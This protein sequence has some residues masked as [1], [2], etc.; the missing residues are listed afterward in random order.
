MGTGLALLALALITSG[1]RGPSSQAPPAQAEVL[2]EESSDAAAKLVAAPAGGSI[3]KEDPPAQQRRR[4]KQPAPINAAP[5]AEARPIG[6]TSLRSGDSRAAPARTG[7]FTVVITSPQSGPLALLAAKV[8]SLAE[9]AGLAARLAPLDQAGRPDAILALNAAPAS[10][11]WYCQPGSPGSAS[12]AAELRASLQ[13]AVA[14]ALADGSA[15]QTGL[16]CDEVHAGRARVAATLVELPDSA[17]HGSS[18]DGTAAA[19]AEGLRRYFST[20]RS[21]LQQA[22]GA[23]RLIWPA[24]GAITSY[25]GPAHP[26]GIDIGQARGSIV[27]ATAGTVVWAGR[28][29]AYGLFVV[30]D[31]G[32]GIRTLYAHLQSLAVS[33]GQRVQAGQA[34]GIVGC[35][36]KCSGTHLHFEVIEGGWRQN[37]LRYLP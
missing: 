30:I 34:L 18:L 26:L 28:D 5:A 10:G 25:Y 9:A 20:N 3:T 22:R 1:S 2:G 37:P 23:A 12:L 17:L 6:G 19:L 27:A 7:P 13:A 15:P 32:D 14:E 33:R 31:S 16:A 11:V 8:A 35:T 36:G 29:G 21:A 4:V 24:A